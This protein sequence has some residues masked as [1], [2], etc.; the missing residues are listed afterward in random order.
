MKWGE[1]DSWELAVNSPEERQLLV[2]HGPGCDGK[3]LLGNRLSDSS[4][5]KCARQDPEEALTSRG[6]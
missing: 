6:S 1:T 3:L 5:P 4:F 2:N